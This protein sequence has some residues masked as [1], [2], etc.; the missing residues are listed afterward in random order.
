MKSND[1]VHQ[2]EIIENNYDCKLY[3]LFKWAVITHKTDISL[4]LS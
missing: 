1:E 2:K 3:L 4:N